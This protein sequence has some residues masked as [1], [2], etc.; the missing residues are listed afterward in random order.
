VGDWGD[1]R[2]SEPRPVANLNGQGAVP[3]LAAA[4]GAMDRRREPDRSVKAK[5]H[6]LRAATR[7]T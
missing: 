4:A 3:V 2:V 6:S 1:G 7:T 5:T